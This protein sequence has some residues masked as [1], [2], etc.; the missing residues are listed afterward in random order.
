MDVIKHAAVGT[1]IVG[2]GL[3]A[4]QGFMARK[5]RRPNSLALSLGSFVGVFRLLEGTGRKLPTHTERR[6]PNAP[7]AAAVAAAVSSLLLEADRKTVLVSYAAVEA[8]LILIKEFTMLADIKYI[9]ISLGALAAGPLIDSWIYQSDAF[10]KS[11]LAALD[12]FCQLSSDVLRRMRDEMPSNKLVSRCDVFHRG[13]TCTQFHSDYFVKGMKFAIRL[14]VPIYAVSVLGPKYKRWIWGPRPALASLVVRYLRTCC[15]LT[16]LYQV[17]LGV[18]CLSRSDRHRLIVRM[19]GALT[20]L[21]FLAEHHHRRGSVMKAVG[22][23]TTG[24]VAARMVT[25]IGL[26]D[27]IVKWGQLVLLSAAIAVIFQHTTPDSSRMVR[28]L[29]GHNDKLALTPQQR[30]TTSHE[31]A[32]KSTKR[33]S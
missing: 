18:S 26:P 30:V 7:Q 4:V 1:V 29:Y 11:Q 20:T 27:K 2:G 23:Y 16:M 3:T 17:P 9:D 12:S 14:Y 28:M 21:A 19:A 15:C 24:T 5:L 31:A 33:A 32:S 22:V 6:F 8:A 25:A 13:Q 10:A